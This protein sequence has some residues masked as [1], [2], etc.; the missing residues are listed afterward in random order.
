MAE[1]RVNCAVKCPHEEKI[2]S[3]YKKV[4]SGN[5]DLPLPERV[6]KME[7]EMEEVLPSLKNLV[8]ASERAE[9]ARTTEMAFHNKRDQEIKDALAISA[10]HT[11]RWMLLITALSFIAMVFS[12][13]HPH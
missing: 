2:N 4:V 6:R 9:G 8:A 11:N 13:F 5:G 7:G 1:R 12:I 3:V 10:Q